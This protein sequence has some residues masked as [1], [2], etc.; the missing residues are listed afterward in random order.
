MKNIPCYYAVI[1]YYPL[2]VLIS[3]HHSDI[4]IKRGRQNGTETHLISRIG[5]SHRASCVWDG[6]KHK[7][8]G[9]GFYC[10]ESLY[11]IS[12]VLGCAMEELPGK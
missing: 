7:D 8:L 11:K 10:A 12:R 6:K 9:L 3:Y 4:P 5:K 2:S 1:S